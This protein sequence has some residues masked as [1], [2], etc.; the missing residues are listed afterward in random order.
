L[1]PPGAWRH[2]SFRGDSWQ[3]I[4]KT[5]RKQYLLNTYRVLLT[6]APQGMVIF[7]PPGDGE[8]PTRYPQFYDP[9]FEYLR[10]LGITSV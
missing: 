2:H 8:D 5:E 7:V 4:H 10:S 3:Q 9:T 1:Q 6:R